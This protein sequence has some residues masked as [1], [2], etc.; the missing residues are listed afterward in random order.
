MLKFQNTIKHIEAAV[1]GKEAAIIP[2]MNKE[3]CTLRQQEFQVWLGI[4]MCTEI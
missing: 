3:L 2:S 1:T 4:R